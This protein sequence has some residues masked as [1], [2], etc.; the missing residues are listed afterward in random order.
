MVAACR[1]AGVILRIAHQLR[2]DAAIGRA[3][4]IVHS[5]RLGRLIAITLERASGLGARTAWRQ[6]ASQSGVI[7]DVGVHLLDLIQWVSNQR[8]VEVSALTYPDRRQQEPDDTITVLGRLSAD[9]Q[10]VVRAT[11]EVASAENNLIIEG[12]EATLITSALRFAKEHIVRVRD[13]LRETEEQFPAS[14]AYELEVLAFENELRGERSLLP[15][16]DNSVQTVAVTQAILQ[17]IAER[18][19]VSVPPMA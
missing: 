12:S 8:F 7:F 4:D 3:R 17:S 9:C 1:D 14:P 13:G 10:A 19:M 6:D 2:L 11:R 5:G 18:R 15:D 16:G